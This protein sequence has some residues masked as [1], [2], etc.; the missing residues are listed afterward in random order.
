MSVL[1]EGDTDPRSLR[2]G[3]EGRPHDRLRRPHA[4]ARPDRRAHPRLRQR[5]RRS[6]RSRPSA[7][8]TARRTRCACSAT[9][10]TA[11]SPPC[12]TSAAATTRCA[13]AIDDGLIRAPRYLLRGQ[14]A[15]DDRRP[16]RHA[17][18]DERRATSGCCCV[19]QSSTVR[20]LAD[21]VDDCIKATR[22]ELRQG[23]HCIKIMGS[24]GVASP[25]DPIWMNQYREDEIR[26]IVHECDRA[27]QLRL[28][29]LPP[30]LGRAALRR[31]RR[32]LASSTA[33]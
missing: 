27:P 19:R 24:G 15:V 3:A 10:S 16:R 25:T 4:D 13:K 31:V 26:A 20:T 11:A 2:Q 22:E 32:A 8:P 1:V 33:R 18:L 17:P 28:R 6:R 7:R 14:G 9:R 30:G 23:A 29:A 21:G 5:R 12:A